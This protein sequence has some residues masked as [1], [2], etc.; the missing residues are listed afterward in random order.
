MYEPDLQIWRQRQQEMLREVEL[1]RLRKTLRKGH[2]N[3]ASMSW[4]EILWWELK[5]DTGRLLKILRSR[6]SE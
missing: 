3:R 5:R 2:G 1:Q 6:R 4:R